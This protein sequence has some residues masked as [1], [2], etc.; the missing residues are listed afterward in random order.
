MKLVSTKNTDCDEVHDFL[1]NIFKTINEKSFSKTNSEK[2]V[3][4]PSYKSP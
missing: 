1:L 4:P 3:P 2:N